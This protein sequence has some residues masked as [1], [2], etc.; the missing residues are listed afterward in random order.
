LS[1]SHLFYIPLCIVAG[2]IAGWYLGIRGSK[3]EVA[4][5][6]ER[7]QKAQDQAAAAR[8]AQTAKN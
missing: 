6:G 3:K 7:L 5:L 4:D 8:L 2:W 1:A